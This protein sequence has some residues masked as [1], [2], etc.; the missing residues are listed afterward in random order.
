MGDGVE[1]ILELRPVLRLWECVIFRHVTCPCRMSP[2][3]LSPE[4]EQNERFAH[5]TLG[6][7]S[8]SR[9]SR[10]MISQKLCRQ[11]QLTPDSWKCPYKEEEKMVLMVLNGKEKCL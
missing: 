5:D 4:D 6:Q 3:G 11:P 7:P 9:Q 10:L 2:V 1:G 8:P